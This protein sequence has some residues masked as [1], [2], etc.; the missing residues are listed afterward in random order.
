MLQNL[1]G[2]HALIILAI[3]LLVF[4]STKLPALARSVGQSLRILKD[5]TH[6]ETAQAAPQSHADAAAPTAPPPATGAAAPTAPLTAAAIGDAPRGTAG[7]GTD[8]LA[9]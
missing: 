5:E 3:V 1:S 6:D 7:A 4:G 2:W 8:R 9:S